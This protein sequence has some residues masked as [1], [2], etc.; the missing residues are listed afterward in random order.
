M[1]TLIPSLRG[2]IAV[3]G[4]AKNELWRRARALP[5]L[6]LRFAEN[7]SLVDARTGSNL[8][9]FTRAST[10]T[11]VGA[12][13]L[14]KTAAVNEARFDHNP[15]TGESLGLLVEEQ[16]TNLLLWSEG[17]DN[18]SWTKTLATVTADAGIA[19]NGLI[20]ADKLVGN[21]SVDNHYVQQNIAG[22]TSG[23]SYTS[24]VY[25]KAAEI[26]RIEILHAVGATLY[27]QGFDL[28]NGTLLTRVTA[29][30][31]AATGGFIQP[32]GNGWYRCG[33][34]QTSDGTSGAI[35]VTLRSGSTIG[36]DATSQGV[37]IWGAQ[38][39]VGAFPT[40]Y[41]PTLP[42]FVSRASTATFFDAN[43]VIQTAGVNVARDNAFAPDSNGVMRPIG[44]LAEE[45]RTNLVTWSEQF[46]NAA[47]TLTGT[48]SSNATLAP[49]GNLTADKLIAVNGGSQGQVFQAATIASGATITG[50]VYIKDG[51][52][53]RVQVVLLSNNNTTPYGRATFNPT[54]GA[55]TEAANS[56][57]GG[58]NASASSTPVGNG[59]Y[60]VTVTVTYPAVT[61]AGLRITSF[62][63]D[64]SNGDGIKGVF[65]WG[66]QFEVGAF[67][68]SYIP[69]LPS[70]V[71]RASTATF[72]D[73]NGVLQTAA[74]NTARSNAFL[75]DSSG[76][77]RSIGLLAEEARTNSIRNNTMV[78]AVAGTPG[79]LPMN[80]NA[81][82]A[83]T[84]L[85]QQIVGT[86][87]ESGISYID[88]RLFGTPSSS[89]T[90]RYY[91][92]NPA[93]IAA[94]TGQ[95]WVNSYYIKLAGG[96]LAGISTF[97]DIYQEFT[98]SGVYVTEG[99]VSAITPTSA[100]LVTQRNITTR[101][102]A[103]GATVALLRTGIQL[104][105]TGTAIDITLRIG[106]PQLEQGA[107]ATSVIPTSGTA[108]T[109]S[110]DVT[111]IAAVTRS[112]DVTNIAAATRS[113]DVASITG[114]AFSSWYRQDEGTVYLLGSTND[115]AFPGFLTI[116]DN[117][118]AEYIR[119]NRAF[120]KMGLL[121]SKA[122][123]N[124]VEMSSAGNVNI[125]EAFRFSF[126]YRAND[127]AQSF[128]AETPVVDTT[129]AIPDPP[130]RI[131]IGLGKYL[132]YANGHIRR[133][134]YWPARLANSILQSI[135]A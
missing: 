31:T 71:S 91:L 124:Q 61:A 130:L 60:R 69:T 39:E 36:F 98:S 64:S 102:L 37:L 54:T 41:I 8:V 12:D 65:L 117:S 18:A 3:P 14:I 11:Y 56:L 42:T 126:G 38:L 73:S 109:R 27:A 87:T 107:F 112:A 123:G 47:W 100:L 30:T 132:T 88:I 104:S 4:W 40:S 97:T 58:T 6:D 29:G 24:S 113:A 53:D 5:S 135:T 63:S 77:M 89:G 28:S 118:A 80:W 17:F 108:V 105:L 49:N 72:F 45:Q 96:S 20:V 62:N 26:S 52:L 84:G 46:D 21:S 22:A 81:A 2:A 9:T 10:G 129:G 103:G 133:L 34:T 76:V 75:P 94:L 74:V 48:M 128:N 83:L 35:R 70:F 1:S 16:R 111:N 116:D 59:W 13:G 93:A 131:R 106:M 19:P 119:V 15:T 85:T 66:A 25:A 92:E 99:G 121:V 79:T 125:S 50:S 95:T 101:T 68:T 122:S 32:V 23:T 51:G 55:I 115:A 134:T 82:S 90:Y 127:F 86:G 114:T 44:L 33:I 7:K 120:G 43:G 78:G 67:F 110:A 57:N